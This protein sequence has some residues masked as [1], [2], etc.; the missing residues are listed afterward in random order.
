M[1]TPEEIR[2]LRALKRLKDLERAQKQG[3][4][5]PP[6]M[7]AAP[8][9]KFTPQADP[10]PPQSIRASF[11]DTPD[12]ILPPGMPAHQGT[13]PQAAPQL[14]IEDLLRQENENYIRKNAGNQGL[15]AADRLATSFSSSQAGVD[16]YLDA[17]GYQTKDL[18]IPD[19]GVL[20]MFSQW[21]TSPTEQVYSTD[22]GKT[23]NRSD[24]FTAADLG[25]DVLDFGG[26][27]TRG[28]ATTAGGFIAGPLGV[29]VGAAVGEII[30]QGA[31]ALL[32]GDEELSWWDRI[33]RGAGNVGLESLFAGAGATGAR[34]FSR[35]RLV[36]RTLESD[37]FD[38]I[39][40]TIRKTKD[41]LPQRLALEQETGIPMKMSEFTS[42]PEIKALEGGT[43][44]ASIQRLEDAQ[45]VSA[46][47]AKNKALNE[48]GPQQDAASVGKEVTD[49][50][51]EANLASRKKL[52]SEF[53]AKKQTAD[54]LTGNSDQVFTSDEQFLG[55]LKALRR[56][57]P[58]LASSLDKELSE[59][60]GV[61]RMQA[62]L[63]EWGERA[64]DKGLMGQLTPNSQKTRFGKVKRALE[65]LV[66]RHKDIK[67]KNTGEAAETLEQARSANAAG[68]ADIIRD[69]TLDEIVK[70]V[71][72]NSP[73]KVGKTLASKTKESISKTLAV[74]DKIDLDVAKK[75]RRVTMEELVK[76]DDLATIV[77]NYR[78]NQKKLE[79][80][81]GAEE[82][83]KT[84]KALDRMQSIVE[85]APPN[86]AP[87]VFGEALSHVQ[88]VVG[89][90]PLT[91]PVRVA[92]S[93]LEK[94]FNTR[95]VRLMNE[96][97]AFRNSLL[98]LTS[99][100][101]K[102]SELS[103]KDVLKL[104]AKLGAR[105]A[106]LDTEQDVLK[107]GES[108]ETSE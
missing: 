107:P 5:P 3:V 45:D 22:E 6:E 101:K 91:G 7:I 76:G 31:G 38:P 25:K 9:A 47:R 35:G 80:I 84:L 68:R 13:R 86:A 51:T 60:V 41:I 105:I 102:F 2:R 78:K 73:D 17:R 34:F 24:P 49:K 77:K 33:K 103:K 85:A 97:R 32:P 53:E 12:P 44:H 75:L 72:N 36:N 27:I 61:P 71:K 4:Q 18:P 26:D 20:D 11:L 82:A 87:N 58:D 19:P 74:V 21:T 57:Q 48:I 95:T 64:T 89:K 92:V 1:A 100:K 28:A 83:S 8:G 98:K 70:Q 52:S 106:V 16:S 67:Y 46:V 59:G 90:K 14:S 50:Y 99:S 37:V 93:F 81:Y 40:G 43:P 15:P 54:N 23:W 55:E 39:T 94:G 63:Q 30:Q 42:S 79:V 66:K 88:S 10:L 96:D 62:L 108:E 56:E 69:P 65:G 104:L 29:P